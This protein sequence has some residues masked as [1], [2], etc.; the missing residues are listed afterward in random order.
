MAISPH[1]QPF[2]VLGHPI[3]HSL[4]PVM[5]NSAFD[6][7]GM[8]AVYLAFDVHPDR[9]MDSLSV[10][11]ELGFIGINLTVPLKE[12]AFR[13]IDNLDESARQLGSVNTVKA[14]G[15]DLAGYSTDGKGFLRGVKDAFDVSVAGLS[16][17]ILGCGGAG[18]AV[19]IACAMDGADRLM[20][21]DLDISRVQKLESEIKALSCKIRIDTVEPVPALWVNASRS[22]DMMVHA[23]PVGLKKEDVPLL[24][25]DAFRPGQLVYDLIYTFP[26][27]ALMKVALKSGAVVSNG[28]GM[29][30]Y[31]GAFSFSIWT[32]MDAPVEIMRKAL[33]Q[34]VYGKRQDTANN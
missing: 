12:V 23:T 24:G 1:T 14:N 4:S 33:E 5:H 28:L 18:R 26:E 34:A 10:M 11:A 30:L 3:A 29:L 21:S 19:A 20:L 31:Q 7:I 22:A 25:S 9:L 6:A 17:F 15:H 2:A 32:E 8:D 13:G 27:T 16:I